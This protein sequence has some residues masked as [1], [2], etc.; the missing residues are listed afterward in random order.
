MTQT[1][2]ARRSSIA[3]CRCPGWQAVSSRSA[4]KTSRTGPLLDCGRAVAVVLSA[5]GATV[6]GVPPDTPFLED[7]RLPRVERGPSHVRSGR[8]G[9]AWSPAEARELP[10]RVRSSAP[11][12]V[13]EVARFVA[14]RS[15]SR[16]SSSIDDPS[17]SLEDDPATRA[18]GLEAD[19]EAGPTR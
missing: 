2:R 18:P 11:L 19:G 16:A 9:A 10:P 12:T 5:L 15:E 7:K 14:G 13:R 17:S 1:W 3:N 8:P 4:K 6:P